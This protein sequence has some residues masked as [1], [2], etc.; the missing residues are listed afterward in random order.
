MKA[1]SQQQFY[2]RWGRLENIIFKI[3]LYC[4]RAKKC[5]HWNLDT[6]H[7]YFISRRTF[8]AGTI[9]SSSILGRCVQVMQRVQ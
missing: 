4:S 1:K 2:R 8:R 7:F 9:I 5:N 3:L 6:T